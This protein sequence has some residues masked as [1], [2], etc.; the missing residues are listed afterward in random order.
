MGLVSCRC[1]I[2][3]CSRYRFL[4]APVS[5]AFLDFEFWCLCWVSV[6]RCCVLMCGCLVGGRRE[7]WRCA[8]LEVGLLWAGRGGA[9]LCVVFGVGSEIDVGVDP[10]CCGCKGALR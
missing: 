9:V 7:P 10:V 5:V 6:L 2:C 8:L 4:P 1:A 3:G